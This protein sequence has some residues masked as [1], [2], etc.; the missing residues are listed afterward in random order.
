MG[1]SR[2]DF[3]IEEGTSKIILNEINTLPGFT[4]ISMY[5]KLMDYSGISYQ[6]LIDK[7]INLAINKTE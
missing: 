5:A 6:E 1:L 4:D 2:I 7:L 3:F